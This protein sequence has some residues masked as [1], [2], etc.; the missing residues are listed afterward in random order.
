M[1]ELNEGVFYVVV[2]STKDFCDWCHHSTTAP[3]YH[4]RMKT[5]VMVV[6]CKSLV[7]TAALTG[8]GIELLEG[9]E[10]IKML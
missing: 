5:L 6:K 9:L 3:Q 10:A 7:L 1:R 2:S 4:S 8:D